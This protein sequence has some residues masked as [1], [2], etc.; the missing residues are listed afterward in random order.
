M[1][2]D[3]ISTLNMSS[4][5][6]ST[7][8]SAQSRLS[9]AQIEVSTGRHSDM[10]LTLGTS[11]RTTIGLRGELDELQQMI[12]G[13]KL[14]G[15]R[16]E[17]TQSA[18]DSISKIASSFMSTL[19]G[20]RTATNGQALARQAATAAMQS[21]RELLNTSYE[22]Q[23]IFGGLNSQSPPIPDNAGGATVDD[24]FLASFGMTQSDATVSGISGGDMKAFLDGPFND[25][26][27]PA[28]WSQNW[29]TASETGVLTRAGSFRTVDISVS[30]RNSGFA[31]IAQALTMAMSLG[32]D[33]LGDAAFEAIADKSL[34][35]L[36]NAVIDIG[37][38]QSRAGLAQSELKKAI[39][40][41]TIK[42]AALAKAVQSLESVDPF[43]AATRVT[44]LMNQ[45]EISY[46][47]TGRLSGLSL[48]KYI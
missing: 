23:Y 5:L 18:M 29:T 16:A 27:S 34:S 12:D 2:T 3:G 31:G 9:I 21:L 8:M 28:G 46:T 15:I 33:K 42:S 4:L 24:A 48:A 39:D 43:E 35:L 17:L 10:G 26:F 37:A 7:V 36:G 38:E 47:I 32:E 11:V 1:R 45:L 14:A 25:L 30:A 44:D 19:T 22:G 20:A 13:G 6:R 41:M 40:H